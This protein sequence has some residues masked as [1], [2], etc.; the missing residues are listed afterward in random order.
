MIKKKK[1]HHPFQMNA[2]FI[3]SDEIHRISST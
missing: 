2:S 1:D 3:H